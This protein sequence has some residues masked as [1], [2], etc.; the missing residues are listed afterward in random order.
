MYFVIQDRR[1]NHAALTP[2]E[3]IVFTVAVATPFTIPYLPVGRFSVFPCPDLT[4]RFE[5]ERIGSMFAYIERALGIRQELPGVTVRNAGKSNQELVFHNLDHE[6][7]FVTI[8]KG[9]AGQLQVAQTLAPEHQLFEPLHGLLF[10]NFTHL[11]GAMPRDRFARFEELVEVRVKE[12]REQ[13]LKHNTPFPYRNDY[14]WPLQGPTIMGS[15]K[16]IALDCQW[17][18]SV[19]ER[20]I[21]IVQQAYE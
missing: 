5:R 4:K 9:V 13:R 17:Y 11:L 7:D 14:A 21:P 8:T 19:I 16:S 18:A 15:T 20:L 12:E 1:M 3:S 2:F 10:Q 6:T